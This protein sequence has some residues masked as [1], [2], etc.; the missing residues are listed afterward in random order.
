MWVDLCIIC[1]NNIY[2]KRDSQSNLSLFCMVYIQKLSF[3]MSIITS[4]RISETNIINTLY[5][6]YK[7][8]LLKIC[9]CLY[10]FVVVVCVCMCVWSEFFPVVGQWLVEDRWLQCCIQKMWNFANCTSA[11]CLFKTSCCSSHAQLWI[12]YV[13][14]DCYWV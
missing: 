9:F 10:K 6:E 11:K 13:V 8:A 3:C 7:N 12:F 1:V 4:K 14:Y 5:K 2:S